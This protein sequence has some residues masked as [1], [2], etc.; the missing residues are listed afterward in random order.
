MGNGKKDDLNDVPVKCKKGLGALVA[1]VLTYKS[2]VPKSKRE[3][4]PGV[5]VKIA[6]TT[7][8]GDQNTGP[9]GRTPVANDLEPGDYT[10]SLE[11][12]PNMI[13]FYDIA[14]STTSD[15]KTVKK[16][17]TTVYPFEVPWF[18]VEHHVQYAGTKTFVPGIE[19]V[20]RYQ[21]P[22][23]P[24]SPWTQRSAGTTGLAKVTAERVPRGRYKLDL[25]LVYDPVWGDPQVEIDKPIE[26]MA[27]VSGFDPGTNGT[28][29]IVDLHAPTPA[30]HTINA[31]VT[32][33]VDKSKRELKTTWTPTKVQ[34]KDLK[35]AQ[36]AFRAAVGNS[37]VFSAPEPVFIK[38]KYEVVDGDG[39]KLTTRIELRFSGG[40]IE[41]KPV[42]G[43]EVDVLVPWN[44]V[45]ARVDLPDHKGKRVGL[46]EGGIAGRS[47]WM[48]A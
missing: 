2:Q 6:G 15:T 48:P 34:L 26:I 36:I 18:W 41:S 12:P 3:A 37:F 11:F 27:T 4:L 13:D 45:I 25:K 1:E 30:L 10:V 42:V 23:P 17:K 19:Y 35:S 22:D 31:T 38:E 24:N 9:K 20:L 44:Q 39:N 14:G 7:K 29:Q 16:S 33:S 8:K 21:K 46:D 5:K 28:I 47:F 43:G 40:H 32:E